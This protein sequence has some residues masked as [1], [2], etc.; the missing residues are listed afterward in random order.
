MNTVNLIS[1]RFGENGIGKYE[2]ALYKSLIKR[3]GRQSVHRICFDFASKSIVKTVL[4]ST[5]IK[6]SYP[7][8]FIDNHLLFGM[9]NR[10]AISKEDGS[11]NHI[12]SQTLSFL[13]VSPKVITCHD[14]IPYKIPMNITDR[15]EQLKYRGLRE[16]DAVIAISEHTRKDLID[17]GV[18]EKKIYCI[19]HGVKK[20]EVSI[21]EAAIKRKY[22]IPSGKQY[23]LYVGTE[24]PRKNFVRLLQAFA[25]VREYVIDAYI[26]KVGD[27][28]G[29]KYRKQSLKTLKALGLLNRVTFTDHVS[30]EE[31]TTFYDMADVFVFP[32]LYEGFG[33]PPLE[34]MASGTP[35]ISSNISSLPEVIGNAGI[36]VNPYDVGA[37]AKEIIRVLRSDTLQRKM[38]ANGLEQAEQFTWDKCAKETEKV[39]EKVL[40]Y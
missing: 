27:A 32:S 2:Q 3:N 10:N 12:V 26:L 28:G 30:E 31:L 38:K 9:R 8:P 29:K 1:Y 34:A 21:P 24:K 11:I 14:I 15:V 13:N 40:C 20:Q 18:D 37:L 23:I 4:D 36:M 19:Y 33:L 16:A 6:Q 17:F 7:L 25:M 5:I 22:N 35:V 39:Y